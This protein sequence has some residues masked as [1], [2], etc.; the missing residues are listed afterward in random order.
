M[1]KNE[2]GN[3]LVLF[4]AF[5]KRIFMYSS[6]LLFKVDTFGFDYRS[7]VKKAKVMSF[8]KRYNLRQ[9]I[10]KTFGQQDIVAELSVSANSRPDWLLY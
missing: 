2:K 9:R 5:Q 8:F 6:P 3:F 1:I 10:S 4:S 7:K